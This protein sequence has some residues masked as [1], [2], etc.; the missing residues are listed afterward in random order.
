MHEYQNLQQITK[1]PTGV[2]R[3]LLTVEHE[4]L[5]GLSQIYGL[6][7]SF[8]YQVRRHT[9]FYVPTHR[10]FVAKGLKSWFNKLF[11]TLSLYLRFVRHKISEPLIHLQL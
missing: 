5:F 3:A 6:D 11:A 7:N 8:A 1:A 4:P 9:F 10:F 2:L